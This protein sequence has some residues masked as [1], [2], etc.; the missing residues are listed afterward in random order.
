[1]RDIGKARRKPKQRRVKSAGRTTFD[2]G[3]CW[4]NDKDAVSSVDSHESPEQ[5]VHNIPECEVLAICRNPISDATRT[6]LFSRST[7]ET[8]FNSKIVR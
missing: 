6:S 1:M 3:A 2:Q 5:D 7:I 4:L 8:L